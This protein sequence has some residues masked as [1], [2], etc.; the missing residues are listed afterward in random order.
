LTISNESYGGNASFI[1]NG[2]KSNNKVETRKSNVVM[3]NDKVD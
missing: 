1:S 2:I 3:G